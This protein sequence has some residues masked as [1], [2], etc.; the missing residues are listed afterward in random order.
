MTK[1]KRI[2]VSLPDDM[3]KALNKLRRS[4]RFRGKPYSE[5]IRAMVRCGLEEET[6]GGAKSVRTVGESTQKH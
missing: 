6:K 5:I 1:M 2:T 3:V 4:A